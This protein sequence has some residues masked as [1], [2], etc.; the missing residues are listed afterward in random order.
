MCLQH[1]AVRPYQKWNWAGNEIVHDTALKLNR[2]ILRT[3]K[4]ISQFEIDIREFISIEDNAVVGKLLKDLIHKLP[5]EEQVR[6]VKTDFGDRDFRVKCCQ[7]YLK[8]FSY[9]RA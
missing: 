5:Q 9:S 2:T 6:F 4:R 3:G 8:H 1:S 7:E